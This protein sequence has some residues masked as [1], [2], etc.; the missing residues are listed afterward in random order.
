MKNELTFQGSIY[1]FFN[2]IIGQDEIK[3]KLI[4]SVKDNRISHAQL[5]LGTEGC[6]SLLLSIAYSQYINCYNRKE[7]DS[8]GICPSCV[9]FSKL[10]HPDLHFVF[11]VTTSEKVKKDPISENYISQWRELIINSPYFSENQWY[12]YIKV[13]N[14][15]GYISV[16]ES[17]EIIRKLGYKTYEAEYKTMIIWLPERMNPSSANKILKLLEEPEDKTLFIMVSENTGPV[18]PTILSRLQITK[19]AKIEK[20]SIEKSLINKYSL[21]PSEAE[22]IAGIANG[23]MVKALSLIQL[24]G[25]TS[26]NLSKFREF[27]LSCYKHDLPEIQNWIDNMSGQ[28]REKIKDF[29]EFSLRII[30]E[31]LMINQELPEITY[32]DQEE[33]DFSLKFSKFINLTNVYAIYEEFNN[34]YNYIESN[35]NNKIVFFDL[36][37]KIFSLIKK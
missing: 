35:A 4:K 15:Q 28:G 9:K 13:E 33:K 27:M 5:F 19:L 3:Q 37:L 30:R 10:T 25:E 32:M 11:P 29:L 31:N 1:M 12:E 7:G 2:E 17:N 34:A 24:K 22:D 8:C 6:G 18:L 14:K 23:N 16:K 21:S 20:Q 26:L 36:A